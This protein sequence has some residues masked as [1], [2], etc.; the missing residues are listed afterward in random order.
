MYG[1]DVII[2]APIK[3]LNVC[4]GNPFAYSIPRCQVRVELNLA[5]RRRLL[6]SGGGPVE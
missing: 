5:E 4:F 1:I 2:A 6:W 3:F